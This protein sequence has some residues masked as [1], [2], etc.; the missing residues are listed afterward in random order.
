MNAFIFAQ[1]FAQIYTQIL[2]MQT[3]YLYLAL[4]VDFSNSETTVNDILHYNSDCL[5]TK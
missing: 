5:I 2:S 4:Q 3:F 1:T